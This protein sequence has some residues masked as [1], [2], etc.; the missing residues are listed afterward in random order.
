MQNLL[1]CKLVLK[2]IHKETDSSA[3]DLSMKMLPMSLVLKSNSSQKAHTIKTLSQEM[4]T[5]CPN[6]ISSS[7][8]LLSSKE[9]E[10]GETKIKV[11]EK[12]KIKKF[13]QLCYKTKS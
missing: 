12:K 13:I 7:N 9:M 8:S 5:N 11:L 1:K 2:D 6:K 4:W 3:N 10:M